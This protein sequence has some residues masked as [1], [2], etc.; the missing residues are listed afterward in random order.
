MSNPQPRPDELA[1]GRPIVFR[2]ATVITVDT[3]GTL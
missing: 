3:P 1:S 2:N